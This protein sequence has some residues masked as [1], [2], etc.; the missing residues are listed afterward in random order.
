M[1][2]EETRMPEGGKNK[3]FRSIGR[4]VGYV[5]MV[6]Q[7][8]SGMLAVVICVAM[9]SSLVTK[10]QKDRCTNG[11]N[12]L[13]L[14]LE[15]GSEDMDKNQMLDELKNRMGC[16][17]TIFEGDTRAYSTVTQ[18]GKRAVGTKLSSEVS[19]IVLQKGQAYVGEATI[20]DE[21]YLCSYVPTRGADGKI[22]GL[23]FAG[24]SMAEAKQETLKVITMAAVAS[25]ITILICAVVMAAYLKKRVSTPLGEI[26]RIASKL[27]KGD[28]GLAGGQEVQINVQSDDEIGLLGRM[29]ED[30]IRRLRS[31]IGE[32]SDVLGSIADGD[33]TQSAALE[34]L[35][36][37][38]SIKKSLERIQNALNSTMGQI[39]VSADQVSSGSE[40]VSGSAQNLAQGAT[41]QAS[42]VQEISATIAGISDNSLKTSEAVAEAGDF[43][44]QAGAQL[45][46]S[47]DYVKDL[48][49]A[50]ENI[51]RSSNEINTIISTIENIAFQINILALN[52]AVEAARAGSA[53]KGFAVVAD[54]VSN[55][56]SKSDVAA[57]ATQ[58]L[59]ESSIRAVT[60]GSDVVNKVTES[61]NRTGE[62]A[63]NV[64]SRMSVVV[65]AIDKQAKAIVQVSDGIDQI[66]SV[67]QTNSA[68]SEECAAASEELSSQAGLL[69]KLISSFKLKNF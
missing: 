42:S 44:N 68:T 63:G 52:A 30:T 16:E 49:V 1:E 65:E 62:L 41:E 46:V 28:L 48:N 5:V 58:E 32:I 54:E 47:M 61:L 19:E 31:Y 8:V 37:F 50:M 45:G 11:T 36:D 33:L 24:I 10:M 40:Q 59:I 9:F 7:A 25:V 57:K 21:S 18:N 43:V 38:Q 69:K 2:M 66:A 64:T 23:I 26:T 6:L 12:M 35:G 4:K 56:A 53:G 34:Y 13:A 60:E 3:K 29:F 27:E 15:R 67:V 55:L 22:N 14:E 20:L 51:S 17:F 39:A